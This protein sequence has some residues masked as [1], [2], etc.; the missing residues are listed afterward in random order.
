MHKY[1][2]RSFSAIFSLFLRKC[3]GI[4]YQWKVGIHLQQDT[5]LMNHPWDNK[6]WSLGFWEVL[7]CKSTRFLLGTENIKFFSSNFSFWFAFS[8]LFLSTCEYVAKWSYHPDMSKSL[9]FWT[10]CATAGMELFSYPGLVLE[11]RG[12]DK[13]VL[14]IFY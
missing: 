9:D 12:N 10:V 11:C 2:L 13:F 7:T 4:Y 14:D 3:K 1:F 6:E 8:F 5:A